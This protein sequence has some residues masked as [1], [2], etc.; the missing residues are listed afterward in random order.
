MSTSKWDWLLNIDKLIFKLAVIFIV[1]LVFAQLV[2]I[3][4]KTRMYLSKVDRLEG[5]NITLEGNYYAEAPLQIKDSESPVGYFKSLRESR[6]LNLRLIKPVE[7]QIIRVVVNGKSIDNFHKGYIMV[8]VYEGDYVEIDTTSYQGSVQ[9][10]VNVIG[11]KVEIPV[12]GLLLE[13]N[14]VLMPIGKVK[15]KS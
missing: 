12:D 11:D 7:S 13:G 8:I 14:N 3:N 15:F 9:V 2:H 5:E 1:M 10:I 6:V 4:D